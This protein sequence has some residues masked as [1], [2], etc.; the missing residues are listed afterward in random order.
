K[1]FSELMLETDRLLR[2]FAKAGDGAKTVYLTASGTAA[3]EAA[4]MNCFTEKDRLLVI[5]GGSFGQRFV[6]ICQVHQIPHDVVKLE[7]G[8]VLT[9]DEL[10]QYQDKEYNGLLVNIDETSTGQLYDIRLL[11]DFCRRKGMYLI[12]DAISSFLCDE[13][14]MAGNDIDVMIASSQK[15]ACISP[16]LS[17]VILSQRIIRE[18]VMRN[19]IRSLYFNF[20]DYFRNFERGQTPYTPAVGIC[21]ELSTSLH[22]IEKIGLENHLQRIADVAADFREKIKALPVS[23]PEFPLSNA[24]TPIVFKEPIAYKVFEILKDKYNIFV[25]PTG[26]EMADYSLRI[27]HI[28]QTSLKDNDMLIEKIKA[29]VDGLSL[30]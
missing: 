28:G 27:A 3:M 23:L 18:R 20:N 2:K 22:M 26:G 15:G 8:E 16:G 9:A 12:V 17:M 21:I 29:V 14:D 6:D 11:S 10:V 4:V 24:I 19:N 7:Y 13:F 1:E 25:N 30:K 5:N